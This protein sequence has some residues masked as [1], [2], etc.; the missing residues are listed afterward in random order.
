MTL[1]EYCDFVESKASTQSTKD[2]QSALGTSGLG[3]AG[4]AGEIADLTK[5]VLFHGMEFTP[6]VKQKMIKELG[7]VLWYA[8]FMARVVLETPLEEV[9]Q[10]NVEKLNARYKSGFTTEEFMAKED[11]KK[12]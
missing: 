3:I 6:E 8:A 4:E 5:K 2:L 10:A 9:I 12:E 7:D 1:E 11:C